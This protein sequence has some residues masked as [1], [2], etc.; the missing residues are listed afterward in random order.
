MEQTPLSD[1]HERFVR[2]YMIDQN[3]AQAAIRCGYS[4]RSARVQAVALMKDPRIRGRIRDGLSDLFAELD[5]TAE[6]LLR[7]R[8]RIAFFNVASLF[9]GQGQPIP[10]QFLD[11]DTLAVLNITY[12]TRDGKVAFIRVRPPNRGPHMAALE[13]MLLRFRALEQMDEQEKASV[14][15]RQEMPLNR[16]RGW[17][18]TAHELAMRAAQG[19][20][21]EEAQE[22]AQ[23]KAPGQR[24]QEAKPGVRSAA[25][26]GAPT[27]AAPAQAGTAGGAPAGSGGVRQAPPAP[28]PVAEP[29]NPA[30]LG[31]RSFEQRPQYAEGGREYWSE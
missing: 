31:F 27:A 5:I 26:A 21:G 16:D 18:P 2:E 13:K 28:E 8:A 20:G 11:A 1:R 9:D 17:Q 23:E 6:R 25:G 3:A 19:E 30:L 7:E 14:R 15:E 24:Q 10:L 29:I 22:A 4:P 12:E